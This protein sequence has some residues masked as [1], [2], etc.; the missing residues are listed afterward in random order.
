V[1]T[2]GAPDVQTTGRCGNVAPPAS[3]ATALTRDVAPTSNVVVS[4]EIRTAATGDGDTTIVAVPTCASLVTVTVATPGEDA[5]TVPSLAT[6]ATATLLL[7]NVIA[8]PANNVPL[9]SVICTTSRTVCP[10]VSAACEGD[11]ITDP[12]GRGVTRIL[13]VAVRSALVA[14]IVDTPGAIPSTT[15]VE[16]TVAIVGVL[17]LHMATRSPSTAPASSLETARSCVDC[18]TVIVSL[19]G[20][21]WTLATGTGDTVTPTD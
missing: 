3:S 20:V 2:L 12:T 15:P 4:G 19:T 21:I 10:T 16:D 9:A 11:T 8:R 13:A 18:P 6:C 5:V 1:N 17:E 7:R 14:L